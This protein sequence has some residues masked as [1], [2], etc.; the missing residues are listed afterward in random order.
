MNIHPIFHIPHDG[1]AFPEELMSSV[2]VS[3]E[4]FLRYHEKMRDRDMVKMVPHRFRNNDHLVFFPVSRLLCDVERFIGPQ[5]IMERY[6]MGYCYERAYDGKRIKHISDDLLLRTKKYYDGHHRLLDNLCHEY[7]NIVLLDLHSYSDDIVPASYLRSG[8]GT[9]DVCLGADPER[10]DPRLIAE[11]D[12]AFRRAGF[13]TALNY[14]YTG[15]M[16]P[17][18]VLSGTYKGRFFGVMLELNKRIYTDGYGRSS[19]RS[20]DLLQSLIDRIVDRLDVI[21]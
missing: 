10:S 9:P 3:P 5:E 6:G 1:S 18:R 21:L 20:L 12:N 17:N 4:R 19:D 7:E 13:S 16:I 11:V 14:P 15:C 2:C 8:V